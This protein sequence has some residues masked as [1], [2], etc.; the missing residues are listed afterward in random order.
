MGI[1]LQKPERSVGRSILV[2]N[3]VCTKEV[4]S[5]ALGKYKRVEQPESGFVFISKKK[6]YMNRKEMDNGLAFLSI[7]A[8]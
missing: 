7:F 5:S 8:F 4:T 1:Q 3:T 2:Q 6:T